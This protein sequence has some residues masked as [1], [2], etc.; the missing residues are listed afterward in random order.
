ML[1]YSQ[2]VSLPWQIL[3]TGKFKNE[4]AVHIIRNI[5]ECRATVLEGSTRD[6]DTV[7]VHVCTAPQGWPHIAYEQGVGHFHMSDNLQLILQFLRTAC[8]LWFSYKHYSL[9]NCAQKMSKTCR[10]VSWLHCKTEYVLATQTFWGNLLP[11][12]KKMLRNLSSNTFILV[13]QMQ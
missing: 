13:V 9:L 3:Q 5:S 2:N 11:K 10:N 12:K 6:N 1:R 4:L 7:V 8:H